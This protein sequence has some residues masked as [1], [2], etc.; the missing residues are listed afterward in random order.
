MNRNV[1]NYYCINVIYKPNQIPLLKTKLLDSHFIKNNNNK[2]K[3]IIEN[4]LYDLKEYFENINNKYNHK[5]SIKFKLVF[6]HNII[7]MSYMFY[8]SDSL[9]SISDNNKTYKFKE[10]LGI[11]EDINSENTSKQQVKLKI[12]NMNYIFYN[13]TSLMQLPDISKWDI[14]Q[15]T[16]LSYLFSECKSLIS[17][18]DL[19]KWNTSNV[20]NMYCLFCRCNSLVSLP[21]IS[22]WNTS[23]VINMSTMFYECNSLTS[24]PDIS[25]WNTNNVINMSYMFSKCNS[26]ISLP[27]LSKWNTTNVKNT[28]LIFYECISLYS[29][30]N[31]PK[32]NNK[33]VIITYKIYES[34]IPNPSP[35]FHSSTWGIYF[36]IK[37]ESNTYYEINYKPVK[38]LNDKIKI[39]DQRFIRNNKNLCK[40]YYKNEFYDLKEYFEEIDSNY[41]HKDQ[42]KFI[43]CMDNNINNMSYIF[44]SCDSL[45]SIQEKINLNCEE[46]NS[47]PLINDL[48][49]SVLKVDKSN[50]NINIDSFIKNI[51]Q[52]SEESSLVSS[53]PSNN[54]DNNLFSNEKI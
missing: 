33:K 49:S 26:L 22:K 21:D 27:D 37:N 19:S 1:K 2:C 10:K 32:W 23:K 54:N 44:N 5:G 13:C 11:I 18:P 52:T 6:I 4:K 50:M 36:D 7:N 47:K 14:S 20:N 40:I 34:D 25:N 43:L 17:L 9:I 15:I 39:L 41:N 35:E 51:Y 8:E 30:P 28:G 46:I 12:T 3:I 29:I 16:D 24:F 31:N 53:I 45:I 48:N 38:S 42:F